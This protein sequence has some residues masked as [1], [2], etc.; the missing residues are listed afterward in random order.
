CSPT[1]ADYITDGVPVF[2][3]FQ[4]LSAEDIF[5]LHGF[6]NATQ[7][8]SSNFSAICPAILQQL[9]F[10]PCE[11]QP[12]HSA[13]PSISEVWSYGILSVTIINLAS[14]LGLVLTPLIKKS[15]FPKILTYFVGLAIGTLFSNAIF[16]LIPEAFGFNPKIDNYV[17]KAVAVF[18]GFYML[19]FVE[20]TLKMLLK[21]YGQNDHTHFGNNDFGSKEKA[22]QPKTLPLPAIN[23]VTCYAN[24]AVTEPN[25][26]IHFD[27][28]SVGSLQIQYWK[29][30]GIL[31]GKSRL[32]EQQEPWNH[33]NHQQPFSSASVKSIILFLS[34]WHC[35]HKWET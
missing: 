21:T 3:L 8:T 20:R 35:L 34:P 29:E 24:P 6:S 25:G 10:H 14:L 27:T 2:P 7:I 5:S 16:Q 26:H 22:H 23:G 11:D 19:F 12:K 9:N 17:E 1:C 13:K 33:Q 31:Y 30:M 28:V 4:C 32:L 15:Y 18:G